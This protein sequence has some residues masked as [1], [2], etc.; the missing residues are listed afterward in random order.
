[1]NQGVQIRGLDVGGRD[2]VLVAS[3]ESSWPSGF[4]YFDPGSDAFGTWGKVVVDST[5]RDVHQ[6]ACDTLNGI[7]FCTLG[8]EE[9]PSNAS[10]AFNPQGYNDH[11]GIQGCR[12]AIFPWAGNGF[13][14]PTLV[15]TMGTQ[16]QAL[17][18][19]NGVEYMAGANHGVY[20]AYDAAYNVWT[21]T[22]H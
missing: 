22:L 3:N 7:P 16:N 9:Q 14:V 8:D 13:S 2:I 6:I 20:G 12:V 4:A 1:C 5:Y 11:P 10:N 15:S 19:L 18:Q 21:F 17:F